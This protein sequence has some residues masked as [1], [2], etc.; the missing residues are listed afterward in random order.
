MPLLSSIARRLPLLDRLVAASGRYGMFPPGHFYSPIPSLE[1]VRRDDEAI[2]G[3]PPRQLPGID[4]RDSD[5]VALV[6]RLAEH[7]PDMPFQSGPARD[8]RYHFENP[9]Y[10]YADGTLY[11]CMIRHLRPRRIVEIGSGFSSALAL[12]TN[13]RFFSGGIALTFVEPYPERLLGLLRGEDRDRTR[14]IKSRLQDVPID[15]FRELRENDILFIDST[16]VS[17]VNSD[18]NL[19]LFEILPALHDGVCIHVHDIFFPFE[20]PREWVY[21]GRAW[22]EAY[23]LRAFLQY[24][25]AFEILLMSTYL[26]RFHEALLRERLPRCLANPG[27]SI[28]LRKVRPCPST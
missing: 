3:P 23:L 17:K 2:F 25:E 28:W 4:M 7:Y 18:V 1:E 5:Q 20:Y 8:L 14:L 21:A 10:G 24:N 22:N 11:H 15:V 26:A 27:G 9:F 13:D 16:H 6:E 19:L 12:D